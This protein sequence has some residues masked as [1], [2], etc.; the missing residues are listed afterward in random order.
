MGSINTEDAA[1]RLARVILSDIEL[2]SRERPKLGETLEAQIAEG[3]RLFASRVTPDLRP[4][5]DLVLADRRAPSRGSS[6]KAAEPSS[7]T[8]SSDIT[9]GP[10]HASAPAN[11]AIED[12][13]TPTPSIAAHSAADERTPAPA[14]PPDETPI[15]VLT[16]PAAVVSDRAIEDRPT[17]TASIA[18]HSAA[19]E[20][21]P[22]PAPPA[23][24]TPVPVAVTP[25]SAVSILASDD[26]PTP[27]SSI[28]AHS[29][30]DE[31][32][33]TPALA[34]PSVVDQPG[35]TASVPATPIATEAPA[36]IA[37]ARPAPPPAQEIPIPVLT[38]RVSIPRLLAIGAVVAAM[39]AA[40]THFVR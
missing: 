28:A 30:A 14:P 26:R 8:A 33:P 19:D 34:P 21:T 27:T 10:D 11:P 32:T 23:D 18:A 20:R 9:P 3:R 24:E 37:H 7:T 38:A 17:P 15:P 35:I 2:Y 6:P 29:V 40:L 1:R 36:V 13:P 12:R 31:R 22:A 5:F 25:A 4:V 39:I 16:A